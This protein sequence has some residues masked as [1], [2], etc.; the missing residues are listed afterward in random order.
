M[1]LVFWLLFGVC[2]AI[3]GN[4]LIA[5]VVAS[6]VV[7]FLCYAWDRHESR[8]RCD[9]CQQTMTHAE[10]AGIHGIKVPRS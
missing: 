8:Y 7:A 10:V 9:S 3:A 5:G 1:D 6:V 2:A 4:D